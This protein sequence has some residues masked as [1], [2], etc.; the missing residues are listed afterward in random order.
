MRVTIVF[1]WLR[2]IQRVI[3]CTIHCAIGLSG[4]MRG[5]VAVRAPL[6]SRTSIDRIASRC[7]SSNRSGR[8]SGFGFVLNTADLDP[9]RHRT[10]SPENTKPEIRI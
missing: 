6:R 9:G 5:I 8:Q 1:W 10:V 2:T 3:S 4:P 7:A